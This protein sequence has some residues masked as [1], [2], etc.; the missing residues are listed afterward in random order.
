MKLQW[1]IVERSAQAFGRATFARFFISLDLPNTHGDAWRYEARVENVSGGTAF[2]VQDDFESIP[3]AQAWCEAEYAR[4]L[5]DELARLET[6]E[7]DD[8][9]TLPILRR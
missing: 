4:L 7:R 3:A 9:T 5:R 2:V 6:K 1:D 8:D